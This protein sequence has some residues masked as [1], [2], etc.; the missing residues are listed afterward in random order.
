MV[1]DVLNAFCHLVRKSQEEGLFLKSIGW[2]GI[3]GKGKG[4]GEVA[5]K[6]LENWD[7]IS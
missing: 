2:A 7:P 5:S 6:Y 4:C 3:L 1:I